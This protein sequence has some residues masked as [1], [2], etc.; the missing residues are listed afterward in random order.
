MAVM[1]PRTSRPAGLLACALLLSALACGGPA[2]PA[3]DRAAAVTGAAPVAAPA[4]P[5]PAAPVPTPS[6]AEDPATASPDCIHDNDHDVASVS[7]AVYFLEC[8]GE[9]IPGASVGHELPVGCRLHLNAT[10]RDGMGAPTC[11][12]SW[13]VWQWGPPE[14][15]SG[16]GG[17]TFTPAYA[18]QG[19]GRFWVRCIVDGVRSDYLLF[20]LVDRR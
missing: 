14:L 11:S 3:A 1:G 2:G 5:S 15:V 7:L 16:G 8:P 18:I 9:R 19:T 6:P 20:D 12:R 17:E 13:P 4:T 10:P